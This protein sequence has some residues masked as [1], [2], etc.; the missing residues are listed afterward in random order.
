MT[1]AITESRIEYLMRRGRF[2][3]AFD[4]VEDAA[5]ELKEESADIAQRV[6]MLISKAILFAKLKKPERGFSVALRAACITEKAK[7]L[8]G[9]WAAVGCLGNILNELQDFEGALKMLEAVVPQVCS[10][11]SPRL[12]CCSQVNFALHPLTV[13]FQSLEHMDFGLTARLYSLLADSHIGLAGKTDC[14]EAAGVR[15]RSVRV[16]QAELCIDR[17]CDCTS[18]PCPSPRVWARLLFARDS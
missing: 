10:C 4:A 1:F 11:A 5:E 2:V 18:I 15:Q 14:D 7:L 8:P 16:S 6:A 12:W 9:L 3:Q 13:V 17:A